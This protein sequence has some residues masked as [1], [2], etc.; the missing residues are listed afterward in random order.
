MTDTRALKVLFNTY[1]SP[2]GWKQ[3]PATPVADLEYA[4]AAGV[5][6]PPTIIGHDATVNW[7][8]NG[9]SQVTR[10]RV[11]SAFLASLSSRRLELR[12]A[13]GSY[14]VARNFPRHAFTPRRGS[15][16]AYRNVCGDYDDAELQDLSVL[17][18]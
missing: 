15:P 17:N 2:A 4:I 18:F 8:F 16:G 9:R 1:W 3:N 7:L 10:L 6:F 5:M 13:L 14:A 11:T 12:S